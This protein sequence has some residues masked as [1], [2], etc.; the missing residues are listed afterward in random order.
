M[1]EKIKVKVKVRLDHN[2]CF[3]VHSASM[4]ES[5]PQPPEKPKE[6]P[7]DTSESP[8]AADSAQVNGD[9]KEELN[10][11]DKK[12]AMVNGE[13]E[14]NESS[15]KKEQPMDTAEVDEK[16]VRVS[17]N[18]QTFANT[19][20]FNEKINIHSGY[21]Q[22]VLFAIVTKHRP[23]R[24]GFRMTKFEGL[25]LPVYQSLSFTRD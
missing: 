5:L 10:E 20:K 18:F 8:P 12:D 11:G 13:G 19:Q 16:K 24:E 9:N 7:M 23:N 15:E 25:N 1:S 14:G 6:E 3:T 21:F 22:L 17:V 2:G 4:V